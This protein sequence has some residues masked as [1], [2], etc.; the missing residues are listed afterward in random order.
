[1]ELWQVGILFE[2][3]M[4]IEISKSELVIKHW[5]TFIDECYWDTLSHEENRN[6]SK[7]Y[8]RNFS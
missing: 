7:S 4:E 8:S 3:L 5:W 6:A 2:K 1:M